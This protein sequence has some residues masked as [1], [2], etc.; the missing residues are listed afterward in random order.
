MTAKT[1]D[2]SGTL[3]YN[4]AGPGFNAVEQVTIHCPASMDEGDS[5]TVNLVTWGLPD[6]TVLAH[7][8]PLTNISPLRFNISSISPVANNRAS[9][10]IAVNSDNTTASGAQSFDIQ[11]RKTVTSDLLATKTV[12]I[13]DTSQSAPTSYTHHFATSAPPGVT[14]AILVWQDVLTQDVIGWTMTGLDVPAGTTVLT[15]TDNGNQTFMTISQE[16]NYHAVDYTFT[17]P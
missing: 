14:S 3:F 7:T 8:F 9:F 5:F 11:I 2:F 12:T 4:P 15:Q 16:I 13:N 6:G 17:A 10:F 1:S